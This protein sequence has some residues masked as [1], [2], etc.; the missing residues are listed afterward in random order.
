MHPH[1][2]LTSTQL[3]DCNPSRNIKQVNTRAKGA[4]APVSVMPPGSA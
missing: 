1:S 3:M 2:D 4:F